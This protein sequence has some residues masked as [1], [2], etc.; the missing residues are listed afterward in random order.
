VRNS[1]QPRVAIV[2]TVTTLWC[3]FAASAVMAQD[4]PLP[5]AAEL[6]Y[7]FR[8]KIR[9]AKPVEKSFSAPSDE[10]ESLPLPTLKTDDGSKLRVLEGVV[11]HLPY[12]FLIKLVRSG[13]NQAET[14][15]VNILDRTGKSLAG[16][17]QSMPN[18]LTKSA[19]SSRKEFEI[20]LTD[21]IK[22]QI[23]K[24]LLAKD[25]LLTHVDLVIGV[26][27]EFLSSVSSKSH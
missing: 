10:R 11:P 21:P 8:E 19:E 23:E 7:H 22:A 18:P 14:L 5:F 2:A 13:A 25:Q 1:A 6:R 15:E 20:P 9:N 12:R 26:D 3:L 24:T 4:T 17:P 16:F 27:D